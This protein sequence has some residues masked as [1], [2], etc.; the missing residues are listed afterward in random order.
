MAVIYGGP[1][2][3]NELRFQFARR[4]VDLMPNSRGAL[5][6]IPGVVSFGQSSLLDSSRDGRP[7]ASGRIRHARREAPISS[8]F[9]GVAPAHHVSMR[10]LANRFA[11]VFIFPTLNDF[12]ARG[13]GR[14]SSR[15]TVIRGRPLR[16]RCRLPFGRRINGGR[17]Q[18]AHGGCVAFAT[19]FS[20]CP[21]LFRTATNRISCPAPRNRLAA[22]RSR[23]SGS[24]APAPACS[25]T[26]T[27]S[28]F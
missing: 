6:E 24:S 13:A 27:R 19:N 7:R 12:T 14:V 21:R 20:A 15:P 10:S 26:A 28:R 25:T 9:G 8:G 22:A 5:L 11:G 2:F 16:D 1:R 18:R 3:V 4:S 17:R 23:R